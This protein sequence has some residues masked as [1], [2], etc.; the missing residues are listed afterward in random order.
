MRTRSRTILD[1]A[2]KAGVSPSTVSR[3]FN[4]PEIVDPLTRER[5]LHIAQ[6]LE[7]IPNALARGLITGRSGFA[8]L[9]V[10]DIT[11]PF[12]GQMAFA[13]EQALRPAGLVLVVCHTSEEHQAEEHLVRLLE[14]RQMD[15]LVVASEA[16]NSEGVSPL[17]KSRIPLVFVERVSQHKVA[18]SVILDKQSVNE[19]V[20]YLYELGHRRIAMITGHMD[21][22]GGRTLYNAFC[23][24]LREH[25]L[26][27]PDGLTIHG[28]FKFEKSR[29]AAYNLLA[30][31]SPPTA[32]FV[33]SDRMAHGFM[34]GL[35]EQ[36]IQVPDKLSVIAFSTSLVDTLV[37]PNLTSCQSSYE[38]V[39]Q[40][41]A[42]LLVRRIHEPNAGIREDL[43]PT[44][45][46]IRGSC[47]AI[48]LTES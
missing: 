29:N 46:L 38:K 18:D 34:T 19:A 5:V 43:I 1:V 11:D 17:E 39:G 37:H 35:H 2:E 45:L 12:F 20:H 47:R 9:V 30:L 27:L 15:A 3:V 10:P 24:A 22:Y 4:K 26:V 41:A 40:Q 28:D 6:E 25:G 48:P 8:A 32:V 42:A 13:L 36:G 44:R 33:G 16:P 31:D 7:F 23:N 21:T 14:E